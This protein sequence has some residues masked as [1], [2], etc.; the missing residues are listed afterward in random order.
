M[1]IKRTVCALFVVLLSTTVIAQGKK[2]SYLASTKQEAN[3]AGKKFADSMNAAIG[4]KAKNPVITDIPQYQ[5]ENVAAKQYYNSGIGIEDKALIN[6]TTD[7]TAR[8]IY[9]SRNSRPQFDI[10]TDKDPLFKREDDIVDLSRS[11]T[12]TYSGCVSL[13]VGVEDTTRVWDET[14]SVTANVHVSFPVCYQNLTVTA[15]EAPRN[16]KKIVGVYYRLYSLDASGNNEHC[17]MIWHDPFK[18]NLNV[19]MH[20]KQG[21]PRHNL[22]TNPLLFT[23]AHPRSCLNT[24]TYQLLKGP[25]GQR[26]QIQKAWKKQGNY[27]II[28]IRFPGIRSGYASV[29]VHPIE[30]PPTFTDVMSDG[31]N[32]YKQD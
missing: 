10:D 3:N 27:D 5:G 2:K 29:T 30:Q 14:C 23:E 22:V 25:K 26:Y 16:P 15:N 32:S 4:N 24:W 8:Y 20:V 6:A 21:K 18:G 13:P 17:H 9:N 12:D 28:S 7:P 1:M 11:L 19:K 31:C